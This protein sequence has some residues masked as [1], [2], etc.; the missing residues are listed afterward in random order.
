MR[1]NV[2]QFLPNFTSFYA[3]NHRQLDR[4]EFNQIKIDYDNNK[5]FSPLPFKGVMCRVHTK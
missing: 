5:N 2:I 1:R 3:V 4:E